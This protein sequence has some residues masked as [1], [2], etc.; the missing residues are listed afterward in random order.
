[1]KGS[2]SEARMKYLSLALFAQRTTRALIDFVRNGDEEPMRKSLKEAL[3]SF[4]QLSHGETSNVRS[5]MYY[6]QVK[7]LHDMN[8][9]PEEI[10]ALLRSLLD[11]K[12]TQ[13]Q[14]RANAEKRLSSFMNWKSRRFST[15]SGRRKKYRAAFV[16]YARRA[17]RPITRCNGRIQVC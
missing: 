4:M 6:E 9:A 13:R 16:S 1:M 11:R 12:G 8:K 15:A 5:F 14:Q 3:T 2:S 10:I 7:T 17:E